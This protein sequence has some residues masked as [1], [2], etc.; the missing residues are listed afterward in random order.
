MPWPGF[1]TW[2]P[3]F[4]PPLPLHHRHTCRH[5]S[6]RTDRKSHKRHSGQLLRPRKDTTH[7]ADSAASARLFWLSLRCHGGGAGD[8]R[9]A[10]GKITAAGVAQVGAACAVNT[11]GESLADQLALVGMFW[12]MNSKEKRRVCHAGASS[13]THLRLWPTEDSGHRDRACG[14][15]C[16]GLSAGGR[17]MAQSRPEERERLPIHRSTYSQAVS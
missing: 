6:S 3:W 7:A 5:V 9:T 14:G 11:L 2:H 1:V 17:G 8:N 16:R 13:F 10:T 12:K 15:G 4:H